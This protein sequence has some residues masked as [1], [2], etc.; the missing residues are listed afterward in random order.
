MR[1]WRAEILQSFGRQKEALKEV[2]TGLRLDPA[3]RLGFAWRA[4]LRRAFGDA[5][6]AL[7]DL[8]EVL[9]ALPRPSFR[10]QRALT[11]AQAG[12]HAL[13]YEDLSECVR[14]SA[15]HAFGY[16]PLPW[17]FGFKR[18]V[19]EGPGSL[20]SPPNTRGGL[21][22][23]ARRAKRR[24]T[25]RRETPPCEGHADP[26]LFRPE[27]PAKGAAAMAWHGRRQLDADRPG[28]A[29][30][31]LDAAVKADP[32]L[33]AA[34]LW[35]GEALAALKKWAP[36]CADLD[37]AVR[38]APGSAVARLW[39]C[40]A[41]WRLGREADAL[42]DLL[43]AFRADPANAGLADAWTRVLGPSP[44]ER[45]R[46]R[47]PEAR[48]RAAELELR[49]GRAAAASRLLRG[50]DGAGPLVLRG[51]AFLGRG[52][53]RQ[54]RRRAHRRRAPVHRG[55]APAHRAPAQGP[56]S[57]AASAFA[58]YAALAEAEA[59]RGR[60]AQRPEGVARRLA[61]ESADETPLG[62]SL[63]S[64]AALESGRIELALA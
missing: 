37:E 17:L 58:A 21:Y 48:E 50:L 27:T 64:A 20:S 3:Y 11:A 10:Y 4:N 34:R 31:A 8:T 38:L 25:D 51:F 7:A 62:L 30:V 44:A 12:R 55:R 53:G 42:D 16:S 6:G 29:L 39:R 18:L 49:A 54:R 57:A 60:P 36:A 35:R 19:H 14:L 24:A 61:E 43:A 52:L 22:T 56:A 63:R 47:S 1:C 41:R 40:L 5:K 13:V 59:R 33:F 15:P 2:E 46:A 9:D 28:P 32:A 23:W 26:F 45:R